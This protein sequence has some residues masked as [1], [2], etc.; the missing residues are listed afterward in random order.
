MATDESV[1]VAVLVLLAVVAC[2]LFIKLRAQQA[3]EG[4]TSTPESRARANE[5]YSG[6]QKALSRHGSDVTFN[7]Y[8]E[9]RGGA[10]PIE[11]HDVKRLSR[12]GELSPEK[13]EPLIST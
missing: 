12:R 10:D 7:Q 2:A 3:P 5:A 6:A 9:I 4:F 1:K 8:K 11:F 13:L